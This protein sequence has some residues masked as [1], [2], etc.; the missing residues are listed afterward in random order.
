[1]RKPIPLVFASLFVVVVVA[2]ACATSPTGRS[3]LM[4]VPED[5]MVELGNQSFEQISQ[6]IPASEDREALRYVQCVAGEIT[7]ELDRSQSWDVRLF[8]SEDTNAFAVPG[9]HIGVFTGM[10]DVAK[11]Q[12]QL[13]TV[14]AHEVGHLVADH[15]RERVS[16]ALLV[17]GGLLAVGEIMANSQLRDL[18]L[19]ALGLGAQFGVLMPYSRIQENEADRIGLD[20]MARAGFDPEESVELWRNMERQVGGSPPEF[21]STHPSHETRIENLTQWQTEVRPAY[22]RAVRQG[23]RP[24]CGQPAQRVSRR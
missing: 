14:V 18:A 21:L 22:E 15:S 11:N 1:M 5:Q 8:D 9:N 23:G 19:G 17:E 24:T 10:L 3:Q 6:E 13:A 2:V 20:L 7:G 12:D 4:L 16:Q